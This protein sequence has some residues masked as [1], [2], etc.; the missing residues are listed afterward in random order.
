MQEKLLI[1]KNATHEGPGLLEQLLTERR[2]E[3]DLADLSQG[4]PVPDPTRY[5]ALVVLGGP[6]SVNDP[7]PAMREELRQIG[8]A[9]E[10]AVPYLGICLGMQAL[11]HAAGGRVVACPRK[12]TGFFDEEGS[13]FEM[14]LTKEGKTDPLFRGLGERFRVFQLHGETVEPAP[15]TLQVGTADGCPQQAIRVGERAWGLQCHFELTR[16]M[17]ESWTGI[18]PDLRAMGRDRVLREFDAFQEEYRRTGIGLLSNFLDIAG[19]P[20]EP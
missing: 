5:R 18:D 2:I 20:T 15:G 14:E 9:L 13:P 1:L 7:T 12:E 11:V 4:D 16:G 8:R 10:A 17:L 19:F 3:A 6:Q